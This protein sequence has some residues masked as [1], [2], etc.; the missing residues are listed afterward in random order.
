M[1]DDHGVDSAKVLI[2]RSTPVWTITLNLAYKRNAL[3]LDD[4]RVLTE[5]LRDADSAAQ[6]VAVVLTGAGPIFCAGGDIAAMTSDPQLAR[7]R[8]DGL[9]SLTNAL[10]RNS[11]PIVAAVNGGAFGLG[12]ALAAAADYVVAAQDARLVA[13]FGEIGLHADTGLSWTLVQRVGAS[14][15]KAL[16][17][18][19]NTLSAADA[20]AIGLVDECVEPQ[21]L[22]ARATELAGR[23]LVTSAPMI[24]A[25]KQTFAQADQSIDAILAAEAKA[26]AELLATEE[27]AKR[28]A[29][30]MGRKAGRKNP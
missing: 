29:D 3:N 12:L 30:F 24:A 28:Q 22:L 13:S 2:D 4:R 7:V 16:I 19:A 15:A 25:T 17:L 23:F 14:R 11:K 18:W 8:M 6:C 1:I 5:A 27:F 20:H 10:V 9:T 21:T 26:Q